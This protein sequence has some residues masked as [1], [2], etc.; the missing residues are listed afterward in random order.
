MTDHQKFIMLFSGVGHSVQ[1]MPNLRNYLTRNGF[2]PL[3]P[4][5]HTI[6]VHLVELAT[7]KKLTAKLL[8]EESTEDDDRLK[9]LFT[10]IFNSRNFYEVLGAGKAA[11]TKDIV[12]EY[13]SISLQVW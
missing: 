11:G 7:E 13:R 12:Q 3:P 6:S 5:C 8:Q 9:I 1:Q 10:T 2:K 4:T